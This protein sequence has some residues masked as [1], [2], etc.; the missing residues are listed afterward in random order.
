MKCNE[1]IGK[2]CKNKHGASK[3]I[4]TFETYHPVPTTVKRGTDRT[5]G[6]AAAANRH[7]FTASIAGD[8]KISG[9]GYSPSK[10]QAGPS[11]LPVSSP[12]PMALILD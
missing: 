4:D 6:A 11:S 8:H 3:I 9:V 2:W 1:T 12:L 5:E 7:A 10:A